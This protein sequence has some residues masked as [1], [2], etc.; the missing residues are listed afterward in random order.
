MT[1]YSELYCV[2]S[3]RQGYYQQNPSLMPY[4]YRKIYQR[5]PIHV[6]DGPAKTFAV[7]RYI[8]SY[9]KARRD[10]AL[11][12]RRKIRDYYGSDLYPSVRQWLESKRLAGTFA[13]HGLPEEISMMASYAVYT[14]YKT[15]A[16][17]TTW[18]PKV[19]GLDCVGFANAYFTAIKTYK[20]PLYYIP[21][22]TQHGGYAHDVSDITWDSAICFARI[23]GTDGKNNKWDPKK[24]WQVR[25][26]P[27]N[28]SHVMVIDAWAEKYKSLWVTQMSASNGLDTQIYDVLK[29]PN[30]KH[31]QHAVWRILRRG[32]SKGINVMISKRMPEFLGK[33]GDD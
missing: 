15:A 7:H 2:K 22:Y 1:N 23:K 19:F 16:E 10:E 18:A 14:G 24:D 26:N 12:L 13:G 3:F 30:S 21:S 29:V 17:V 33:Q 8:S 28:G 31:R 4:Q 25:P 20:K 5:V 9:T 32:N 11:S 6:P 27:G